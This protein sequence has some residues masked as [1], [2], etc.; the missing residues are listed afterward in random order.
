MKMGNLPYCPRQ[1]PQAPMIRKKHG[2]H[3]AQAR[4]A[5]MYSFKRSI[6]LDVAAAV[7]GC[8]T[9]PGARMDVPGS[10]PSALQGQGVT[11]PAA[12]S[13]ARPGGATYDTA[14][15]DRILALDPER[16]SDDDVRT[17]L[18]AGPTP[19]IILVHG[20]VF[21][22]Y[23]LMESFANFLAGMGYPIDKIRDPHD[24][25]YSQGPYGYSE[26]LA[27][28][29]AWYYERDGVRPIMIGH[30]QGGMQTVK[31]LHDLSGEF[32]TRIAVWN[33]VTDRQGTS[34]FDREPADAP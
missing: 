31:V 13:G 5:N 16:I 32:S 27:G 18:A 7:V 1:R 11:P 6:V 30:S 9:V 15:E 28:E 12:V 22:V 21:P 20:G 3:H 17:L 19:Q 8:T 29:A 34:V 26:R 33:P 4:G 10:A 25:A 24:G 2:D 23:L 14:I